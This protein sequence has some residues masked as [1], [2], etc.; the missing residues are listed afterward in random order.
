MAGHLATAAHN[1]GGKLHR[2]QQQSSRGGLTGPLELPGSPTPLDMSQP[3]A[4]LFGIE[5][6]GLQGSLQQEMQRLKE[7]QNE[8]VGP[9]YFWCMNDTYM[10]T[11][12]LL[13]AAACR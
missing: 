13:Q 6:A 4:R 7:Q 2:H 9:V 1:C 5:L 8:Q 11:P 3:A 10:Y 12:S